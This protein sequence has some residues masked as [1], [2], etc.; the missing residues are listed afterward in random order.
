MESLN[1]LPAF[2][3]STASVPTLHLLGLTHDLRNLMASLALCIEELAKPGVLTTGHTSLAEE[4]QSLAST[5]LSIVGQMSE[6]MQVTKRALMDS[7]VVEPS[8]GL[9]REGRAVGQE[10]WLEQGASSELATEESF[11]LFFLRL[12]RL[13]TVLAGSQ[14]RFMLT[15]SACR[16]RLAMRALDLERVLVN[17]VQN[18]KEAMPQGGKIHIHIQ[19]AV[20][21]A[22]GRPMIEITVQDSGPGIDPGIADRIFDSGFTARDNPSQENEARKARQQLSTAAG[23]DRSRAIFEFSRPRGQGLSIVQRLV[24]SSGGKV[25]FVPTPVG[26]R[27]QLEVPVALV[28]SSPGITSANLQKGSAI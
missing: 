17:L 13:L 25:Q 4:M 19:M 11:E 9:A 3:A 21:S 22:N 6:T 12:G 24:Q 14:I 26:A 7:E 16:G 27:F 20:Q 10:E 23:A 18:A 8:M 5:S 15:R 28:T 2:Q 1:T